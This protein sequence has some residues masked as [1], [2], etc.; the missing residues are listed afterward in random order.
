M[1]RIVLETSCIKKGDEC[2]WRVDEGDGS[3]WIEKLVSKKINL[4]IDDGMLIGDGRYRITQKHY[5]LDN[6]N[7]QYTLVLVGRDLN[8]G[9]TYKK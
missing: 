1:K 7:W 9:W 3:F 5:D 8:R 6:D 2:F 4:D